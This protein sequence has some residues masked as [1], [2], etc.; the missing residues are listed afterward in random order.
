MVAM[1][2][3]QI[4]ADTF[5]ASILAALRTTPRCL[6]AIAAGFQLQR[7]HYR[8]VS[9][10][11][12][13]QSTF[14]VLRDPHWSDIGQPWDEI[15]ARQTQIAVDVTVDVSADADIAAHPNELVATVSLD[16]TVVFDLDCRPGSARGML[17]LQ[18]TFAD[19]EIPAAAALPGGLP[20]KSWIND[21]LGAL[22]TI[23][24][25]H[26]DFAAS[27]PP[28]RY[29]LNAG[30]T[31]HRSGKLIA[32]RAEQPM[33]GRGDA[34]W[35]D[36]HNGAIED[37]LGEDEWSIAVGSADLVLT[38]H[39][40]I[41]N[42]LDAMPKNDV[43]ELISVAVTYSHQPGH[44][45]FTVAPYLRFADLRTESIPI[46]FDMSIDPQTGHLIVDVDAYGFRDI[47]DSVVGIVAVFLSLLMPI[48]G[49][50]LAAALSAVVG[51][52]MPIASAAVAGFAQG[53]LPGAP[54]GTTL[55]E[56]P[57]KP[58]R[59]RASIPLAAPPMVTGRITELVTTPTSVAIAGTWHVLD[60][61]EG[62]LALDVSDFGWQAPNVACGAAGEAVYRDIAEHPM[63]YV[64][65]AA[66]IALDH[67]GSAP[68][69]LCDVTV[70]S[71]L[72]PQA[73]VNISWAS[74]L[75]PTTIEITAPAAAHAALPHP[76]VLEVRTSAGV[77]RAEVAPPGPMTQAD[78]DR[79]RS[80]VGVQLA[81][82]D[83]IIAP[84]WFIGHGK[85]DLG[86]IVDP[87]VDPDYLVD[88]DT[89]HVTGLAPGAR[90]ALDDAA[91]RRLATALAVAGTPT[92]IQLARTPAS[93]APSASVL[94]NRDRRAGVPGRGNDT[95]VHVMR[96]SLQM[97]G[98]VRVSEQVHQV[99]PAPALGAD[100]FLLRQADG[101]LR[102]DVSRPTAP[103]IAAQWTVPGLRAAI[104]TP[105][106]LLAFGDGGS[107]QLATTR[108]GCIER[109]D[110]EPMQFASGSGRYIAAAGRDRIDVINNAGGLISRTAL[111]ACPTGVLVVGN[112]LLVSTEAAT[113]IYDVTDHHIEVRQRLDDAR[114]LYLVRSGFDGA[115]YGIRAD[116]TVAALAVTA[117]GWTRVGDYTAEPWTA[118]AQTAGRTVVHPGDGFAVTVLRRPTQPVLVPVES[119]RDTSAGESACHT[120]T[121]V[122]VHASQVRFPSN[123]T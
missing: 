4:S 89:L 7:V 51:N 94:L 3:L 26:L 27:L 103:T 57:G 43:L 99:I 74:R 122:R 119:E 33:G 116:G 29:F 104:A 9:L 107:F 90:L 71:P 8:A 81:F 58:F 44:A 16:A 88:I 35:T 69:Q 112:Q 32:I 64:H 79:L 98:E 55:Q 78:I 34:R 46:R 56:L 63:K 53:Q 110:R 6:P 41:F 21:R 65:L 106:G 11:R 77:F 36:F 96:E 115:V 72:D 87:L 50:F 76:L 15:T 23:P 68:I 95:G 45:T 40:K 92:T 117:C 75:L 13:V 39:T 52:L 93:P 101:C 120:G 67:T 48:V 100:Q 18:A 30:V 62:P 54:E 105:A 47:V 25:Q 60:F 14:V 1:L 70:L 123:S 61:D 97:T 5:T 86:W 102:L 73:G 19:V 113:Y 121:A 91:D 12:D 109:L 38:L 10:R 20:A 28:D 37:L 2:E 22:L 49:T 42:T 108:Q 24:P 80:T 82:C 31:V 114:G 111:P 59:Y 85:F 84:P 17:D 118:A 83:S 66:E